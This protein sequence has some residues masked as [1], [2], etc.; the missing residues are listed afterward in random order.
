LGSAAAASPAGWIAA[1]LALADPGDY[2]ALQAFLPPDD[3]L[4]ERLHAIQGAIRDATRLACTVGFGPRFLH[5]TG[6]LH[7]GG[8]NRG[9]FLQL[10]TDGGEDLPIPGRS[11]GFG[12][13]FS[14]QA[15]GDYEALRERGRR[16]LRIHLEERPPDKLLAAL[17]DAA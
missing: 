10:T 16:V 11:Y 3:D 7:K 2:V 8:P 6:Q 12:A 1:H 14:A 9:I 15:R 13:L 17:S 5:S 4:E